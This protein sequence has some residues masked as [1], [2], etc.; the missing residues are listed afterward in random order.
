MEALFNPVCGTIGRGRW[1]LFQLVIFGVAIGGLLATIFLF[2]DLEGG[3]GGRNPME[4]VGLGLTALAM[5]YMNLCTCLNRLRDS[6]RSGFWY[7][8]FLLP[9]VGTGLMV[10]FCGIEKAPGRFTSGRS[11]PPAP[12]PVSAAPAAFSAPVR[13]QTVRQREFGRRN[14]ATR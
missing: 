11:D 13:P 12:G 1:W 6:G 7:L 9:S 10:Y 5:I 14:R 4:N 2:A 8:S 3:A